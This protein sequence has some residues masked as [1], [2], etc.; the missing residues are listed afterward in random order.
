MAFLAVAA[1]LGPDD[2]MNRVLFS[3]DVAEDYGAKCLDGSSAGYYLREVEGSQDW[4]IF[5]QGGGL[6]I[7]VIDCIHRANSSLGSSKFWSPTH[8]DNSNVMNSDPTQNPFAGFNVV[9]VPYCSG[10]TWLGIKKDRNLFLGDLFTNGHLILETVLDHLHNTTSM[11]KSV[12]HVLLSG[13]SAGGIG[14]IHNADWLTRTITQKF[15]F[16]DAVVKAS[17]QAGL[18]FPSR[19]SVG[20][21]VF[22]EYTLL[23]EHW[24]PRDDIFESWYVRHEEHSFVTTNCEKALGD[25]TRCWDAGI[26]A[27]YVKTPLFIAQNRYDQNQMGGEF[28]CG[29]CTDD[30]N[31]ITKEARAYMAYFGKRTEDTLIDLATNFGHSVFMP[32]CW[33]HTRNLCMLGGLNIQGDTYSSSLAAWFFHGKHFALYDDC[34]E[35]PCSQTCECQP[36]SDNMDVLV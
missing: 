36:R 15:G 8:R 4:V 17:P 11:K 18:F 3:K 28:L 19:P 2:P 1:A 29:S 16:A 12:G 6:C 34:G 26:T 33:R 30:P 31:N 27:R 14:T 22:P 5:L 23:G 21:C 24:C 13:D 9:Y 25:R 10:D 32:N 20:V 7:E 35:F